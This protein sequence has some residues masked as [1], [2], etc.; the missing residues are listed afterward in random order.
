MPGSKSNASEATATT[1]AAAWTKRIKVCMGGKCKKLGAG[2]ILDKLQRVVGWKLQS[3][4][5]NAW[6]SVKLV[7]MSEFQGVVAAARTRSKLVTGL[8]LAL[9]LLRLVLLYVSELV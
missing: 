5:A 9:L 8:L 2:T 1:I 6:V 3:Q 4:G 7:L